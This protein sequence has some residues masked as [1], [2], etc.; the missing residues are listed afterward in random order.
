MIRISVLGPIAAQ[1][2]DGPIDLGGPTQRRLLASLV[3]ANGEVVSVPTLL[4]HLWGEDP[5]PT[6]PATIQSYVSRLRRELGRSAILTESP[7][8]RF[9]PSEFEIDAHTFVAL[10]SNLPQGP[11]ESVE[12]VRQAL[13]L[14]RGPAFEDFPHLDIEARALHER[15]LTAEEKL[16]SSLRMVGDYENALTAAD[17]VIA[18][19]HLRESAWIER[20]LI[21]HAAGRQPEAIKTLDEYRSRIAEIGLDPSPALSQAED[22]VFEELARLPVSPLPVPPDEFIGREVDIEELGSTISSSSL[23]TV[24]GPG[25]MGKTRLV[26]EF[27]SRDIGAD[28]V[29]FVAL[30]SVGSPDGVLPAILNAVGVEARDQPLETLISRLQTSSGVL[31][32]DNCEHVIDEVADIVSAILLN[33]QVRILTTSRE[34]LNVAGEV[35]INLGP[36]DEKGALDLFLERSRRVGADFADDD[37][38]VSNL[39]ELVDRMPLAIEMAASRSS[40][41]TLEDM[42]DRLQ[43]RIDLLERPRRGDTPRHQTLE[44]LVS[45]SYDLLTSSEQTV[46][47]R[48]S[49][50]SGPF[51]LKAATHVVSFDTMTPEQVPGLIASL[52]E[53]SLVVRRSG[54]GYRMLRVLRSFAAERLGNEVEPR[55]RH[56]EFFA[57]LSTRIGDGLAGPEEARWIEVAQAATDDMAAAIRFSVESAHFDFVSDILEGLFDWFYHRQP[58]A[59]VDWGETVLAAANGHEVTPIA[60]AWASLAA[61]KRGDVELA[62]EYAERGIAFSDGPAA[63]FPMFMA[64]D[65]ACYIGDLDMALEM[66]DKQLVRASSVEDTVGVIDAVA[67][68]ALALSYQGYY[69]KALAVAEGI[70]QT[71]RKTGSPTYIAYADY[72]LGEALIGS[73]HS[74]AITL[75]SRAVERSRSVNNRFIEGMALTAQG[76]AYM[77]VGDGPAALES[78]KG[79]LD[80]YRRIGAVSYTW[81]AIRY[82]A[83]LAAQTGD[84]ETATVLMSAA[85]AAGR[86]PY[87]LDEIKWNQ[88]L[89]SLSDDDRFVDWKAKGTEMSIE[90]ASALAAAIELSD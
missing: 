18:A 6:G 75:F 81:T 30:G 82:L 89:E 35:S 40:V 39:C 72:T 49:V 15:R 13:S 19:E 77:Q 50:F 21:L 31:C 23:V 61:M 14:W 53:R 17:R 73:D 3:A 9:D 36:L 78:L 46:F 48:L 45:W 90:D 51:G 88:A 76:W 71:A 54:D 63:R 32:L 85:S 7:G 12:V 47:R 69:D 79:G 60:S 29:W 44:A 11:L 57:G 5:P 80:V 38:R 34:A 25:G 16:A 52:V 59:I 87:G 62:M 65:V 2:E 33:T 67:G 42:T 37:R 41:L 26:L 68:E 66:F 27:L 84:G 1:S 43:Q 83:L 58:P 20:A 4:E 64:G 10:M 8:Y 55:L 86:W 24:T 74:R 28:N 22:S 70:E 56:A